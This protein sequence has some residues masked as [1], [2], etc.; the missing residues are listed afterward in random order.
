MEKTILHIK[1]D[2]E[3]KENVKRL[4]QEIGLSL[5]DIVN[6]SLRNFIR[7]REVYISAVPRMTPELEKLLGIVERDIK[8]KRNLSPAFSSVKEMEDYLDAL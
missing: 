3:I 5:S 1:T 2:K 4:A 6:A 7:T 8:E